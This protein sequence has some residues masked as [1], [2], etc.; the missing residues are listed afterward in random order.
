MKITT[1]GFQREIK[2]NRINFAVLRDGGIEVESVI[3]KITIFSQ[4]PIEK[5]WIGTEESRVELSEWFRRML[6]QKLILINA[7]N[8][9]DYFDEHLFVKDVSLPYITHTI[10]KILERLIDPKLTLL[11]LEYETNN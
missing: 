6:G 8:A 10:F 2:T 1:N 5:V 7:N 11:S 9:Q 4:E 3:F